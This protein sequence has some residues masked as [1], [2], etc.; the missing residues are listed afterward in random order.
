MA[1]MLVDSLHSVLIGSLNP[2]IRVL[3]QDVLIA[4]VQI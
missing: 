2:E 1:F 3:H 4:V